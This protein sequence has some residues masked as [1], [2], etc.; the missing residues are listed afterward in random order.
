MIRIGEVQ[1]LKIVKKTDFGVY[2]G[3]EEERVLLP[4]K[5]VPENA[6][7]GDTVTVFIYRDSQDRLLATTNKP[8]LVLGEVA[9]LE[10]KDTGKIGAFLD[11]GLEKDLFLP[12][13]EQTYRVHPGDNC[14]VALY[15][16][17]SSRL[18]ATMNVYKYLGTTT[19]Y[20]R[21]DMVSGT[22]Y[23]YIEKFGM[24]VAVDDMY[25]GLI[26]KKECKCLR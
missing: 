13:K 2:L 11:W 26:P 3:N 7:I 21:G 19:Q 23:Q 20:K 6:S 9:R 22:A 12:F 5:Q 10:V 1:D 18:C 15:V 14:L 17:K 16:D 24:Y 25:Q 8:A 4:R